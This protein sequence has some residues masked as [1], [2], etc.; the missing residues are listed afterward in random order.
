M[1]MIWLFSIF[2]IGFDL[3]ISMRMTIIYAVLISFVTSI[4]STKLTFCFYYLWNKNIWA[5]FE[6]GC[7][8]K[9]KMVEE[10]N[11]Y[12]RVEVEI[13]ATY[14]SET[15]SMTTN[16]SRFMNYKLTSR[17]LFFTKTIDTSRSNQTLLIPDNNPQNTLI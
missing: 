14:E 10:C 12:A 7:K 8:E 13:P 17:N 5:A 9:I 15:Q 6:R 3:T 11:S 16:F 1:F 2:M 4:L